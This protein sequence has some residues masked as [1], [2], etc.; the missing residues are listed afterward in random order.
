MTKNTYYNITKFPIEMV[1]IVPYQSDNT[2]LRR[3]G[4]FKGIR[5]ETLGKDDFS[6]IDENGHP[7]HYTG[8]NPL[9]S[10]LL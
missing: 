2:K 8:C 6:I 5:K 9:Y 4:L 10:D 3:G 7:H 1:T